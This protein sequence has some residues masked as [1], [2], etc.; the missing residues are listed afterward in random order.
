MDACCF[1]LHKCDNLPGSTVCFSYISKERVNPVRDKR[2]NLILPAQSGDEIAFQAILNEFEGLIWKTYQQQRVRSQPIDWQHECR[3]V[4]HKTLRLLRNR[5]WAALTLYYKQ[6]LQ[7][8]VVQLWR[9]E[10][11]VLD[12]QV[13]VLQETIVPYE[14][15]TACERFESHQQYLMSFILEW[16]ATLP[17]KERELVFWLVQGYGMAEAAQR[18]QRSRSWC[19]GIRRKWHHI[20]QLEMKN[21]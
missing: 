7:T 17:G 5:T 11:R 3:V 4:L 1:V 13:P 16:Y 2:V 18:I 14:T 21:N 15:E 6:A 20:Y 12:F 9:N 10:Y 19:Y 8:H